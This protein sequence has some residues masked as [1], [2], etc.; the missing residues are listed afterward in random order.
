MAETDTQRMIDCLCIYED[1]RHFLKVLDKVFSS[2]DKHGRFFLHVV[3]T[4]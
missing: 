1:S 4:Y 2:M 3:G